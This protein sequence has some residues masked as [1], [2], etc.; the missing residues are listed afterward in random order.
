MQHMAKKY[1]N[2]TSSEKNQSCKAPIQHTIIKDDLIAL[3]KFIQFFAIL[4]IYINVSLYILNNSIFG[5][6]QMWHF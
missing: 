3:V 2:S 5:K 6:K 4:C 1:E